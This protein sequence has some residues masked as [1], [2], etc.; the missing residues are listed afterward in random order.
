[1]TMLVTSPSL[2]GLSSNAAAAGSSDFL[3][4]LLARPRSGDR[5]ERLRSRRLRSRD[6]LRFFLASSRLLSRSR[7]L[8]LGFSRSSRAFFICARI[9]SRDVMRLLPLASK[10]LVSCVLAACMRHSARKATPSKYNCPEWEASSA[11]WAAFAVL[12]FTYARSLPRC[13]SGGIQQA[14]TSPNWP[15]SIFKAI[16]LLYSV[17]PWTKSKA[18]VGIAPQEGRALRARTAR[19]QAPKSGA[20]LL[21]FLTTEGVMLEP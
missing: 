5:C 2:P 15:N 1:M 9:K 18:V 4:R 3:L 20:R 8:R 13:S 12:N 11:A 10:S 14:V 16:L 7:S 19:E 17:I 21:N 6:R